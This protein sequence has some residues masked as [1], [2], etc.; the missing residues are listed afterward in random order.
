MGP[1]TGRDASGLKLESINIFR[2]GYGK[3]PARAH[4]ERLTGVDI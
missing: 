1:A 4:K 2:S 3:K